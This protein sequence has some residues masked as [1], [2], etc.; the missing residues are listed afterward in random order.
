[1]M[2]AATTAWKFSND[3]L[4]FGF[5]FCRFLVDFSHKLT[6]TLRLINLGICWAGWEQNKLHFKNIKTFLGISLLPWTWPYPTYFKNYGNLKSKRKNITL[7]STPDPNQ[8]QITPTSPLLLK[9]CQEKVWSS[10]IIEEK[11]NI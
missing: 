2:N 4:M 3:R 9:L 7:L 11:E 1:M 8:E 10:P 5:Y 6:R